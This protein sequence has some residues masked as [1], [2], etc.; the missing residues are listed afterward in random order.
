[1]NI[2]YLFFLLFLISGCDYAYVRNIEIISYGITDNKVVEQFDSPD[3]PSGKYEVYDQWNLVKKTTNI[4]ARKGVEFGIEYRVDALSLKS[5]IEVE[6]IIIFPGD[7]ITNPK[8]KIGQKIDSDKTLVS[9]DDKGGFTY[10]MEYDW[11]VVAGNWIFQVRHRDVVYAQ[12][13]FEVK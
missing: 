13:V 12:M 4:P 2:L 7:G 9:I 10:K 1:M 11:E 5:D 3:S 8:T 6:E